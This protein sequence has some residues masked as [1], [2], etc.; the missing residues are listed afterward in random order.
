MD[1]AVNFVAVPFFQF[2]DKRIILEQRVALLVDFELLQ[3]QVGDPVGHIGKFIRRRQRL[4]LLIQNTRQQQTAFQNGD[5]FFNVAF[6][7]QC[8]VKP[9]FDFDILLHQAVA[10]FGRGNQTL[11]EL[12]VNIKLLVH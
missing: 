9:V 4:L 11:A 5:L 10:V 12:M 2:G 6:G 8:A 7:L 1:F 3:T